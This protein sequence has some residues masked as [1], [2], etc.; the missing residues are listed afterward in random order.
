MKTIAKPVTQRAAWKSLAAHSKQS[1]KLHLRKLFVAGAKRGERFTAEAAGF[2]LDYSKNR[3]SEK[4]VKRF[5]ARQLLEHQ[6]VRPMGRGTWQGS[7]LAY[8]S[9]TG[10]RNGALAQARQFDEQPDFC[11]LKMKGAS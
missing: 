9:R 6:F 5:R 11:H 7:H 4:T 8:Y 2:F 1:K 3:I 10:E